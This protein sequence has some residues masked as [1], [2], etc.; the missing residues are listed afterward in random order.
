[1]I[2][3]HP[4]LRNSLILAILFALLLVGTPFLIQKLASDWLRKHGG[5]QVEIRNVDFN[6][7]TGTLV[8]EGLQVRGKGHQ[9]LG[10][11]K[12]LLDIAWLPLLDRH[13]TVQAVHLS[14]FSGVIDTRDPDTLVIGSLHI[15]VR[16]PNNTPEQNHNTGTAW[17]AGIRQLSVSDVRLT[18][19]D[20]TLR[21]DIGLDR[22]ELSV[23]EQWAPGNPANL[24]ARG[25]I[26]GGKFA[27]KGKIKPFADVPDYRLAIS[28][29]QLPLEPFAALARPTLTQL[30]G[31]LSLD[32]KLELSLP[33]TGMQYA[34]QGK[35]AVESLQVW[36]A[37]SRKED[38]PAVELARLEANDMDITPALMSIG[39]L[40][41]SGLALQAQ[42]DEQGELNLTDTGEPAQPVTN[43][44]PQQNTTDKQKAAMAIA[45]G[46]ILVD[47]DS[48]V[49]FSDKSVKPP[50][51]MEAGLNHVSLKQIDTRKPE[52]QSPLSID[53]TVPPNGSLKAEG[54]VQPFV[55]PPAIHVKAKARAIALPPLSSYTRQSLGLKLDSGTLDM[56]LA[57]DSEA[58]KLE[59]KT[60]LKLY[61]LALE[62]VES[63]NS[64]QDQL[65]VPINLALS[66]LRDNNNTIELDIPF[67]G[68]AENPN[69]DI[70]DAIS[71]AL[72][73][74]LSKGAMT[75]LTVALQP[76]GAIFT[77]AKFAGKKL[78]A[79]ALQPV[80]FPAGEAT[81]PESRYPYLGK[82]AGLLDK[83]PK[84]TVRICGTSV[85]KDLFH[86]P[87]DGA[88]AEKDKVEVIPEANDAAVDE[89]QKQQLEA[90]AKQRADNVMT[91]LV[92]TAGANPSQLVSCAPR[93]E[94]DKPDS[95]PRTEL[96]L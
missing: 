57:L 54:Q 83:R 20:K 43:D 24:N 91:Y 29:K 16:G 96:L 42:I 13:I 73:T 89:T 94:L 92:K 65:P 67:S 95:E 87:K 11:D 18:Y 34:Q 17:A 56:D 60:T 30:A 4:W 84:L 23:L 93:V 70:S 9:A 21:L 78:G 38:S 74:A 55:D 45:I 72:A 85:R 10:F 61:Q 33:D 58:G 37:G 7:F 69:V 32:G 35:L 5:E 71:K 63:R 81:L 86:P 64:L 53:A 59:G 6:P 49:H 22:L 44:T 52:Q 3:L 51:R 62:T 25:N 68:D 76:Y 82:L 40:H 27:I 19:L 50:F 48:V 31:K 15:P 66:T 77:A 75:Y 26:N 80:T 47:G 88:K 8:L 39:Q 79:V 12:A 1:M 90:L 28:V 36:P 2:K 46:E 41:L 14:S